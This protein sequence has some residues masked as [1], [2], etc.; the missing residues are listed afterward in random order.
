M[1]GG[2]K[3]QTRVMRERKVETERTGFPHKARRGTGVGYKE[4]GDTEQ[5]RE[6]EGTARKAGVRQDED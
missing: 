4:G 3:A 5:G 2:Q 6:H 1:A